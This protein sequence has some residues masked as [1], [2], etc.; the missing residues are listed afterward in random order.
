MHVRPGAPDARALAKT[1]Y[2]VPVSCRNLLLGTKRSPPCFAALNL[3]PMEGLPEDMACP[4]S[5]GWAAIS[6]PLVP[7]SA[8]KKS[9]HDD[10][11]Q[12]AFTIII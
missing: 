8:M 7:N 2:L 10:Q 4:H 6:M 5:V 12:I 3:P 1:F 9:A 11:P